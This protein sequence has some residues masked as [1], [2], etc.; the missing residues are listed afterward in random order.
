MAFIN[1]LWRSRT[2]TLSRFLVAG[3]CYALL[4]SAFCLAARA[5]LAELAAA[6]AEI[7]LQFQ[8]SASVSEESL[9]TDPLIISLGHALSSSDLSNFKFSLSVYASGHDRPEEDLASSQ[10]C[11]NL[12]RKVLIDQYGIQPGSLIAVGNGGEAPKNMTDP[13]AIENQRLKVRN[14]GAH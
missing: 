14:L 2:A 3:L 4:I 9:M 7:D 13:A 8:C 5:H 12:V 6:D 11:A 1:G 10:R